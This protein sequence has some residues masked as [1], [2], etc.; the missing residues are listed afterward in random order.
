MKTMA[1]LLNNNVQN[2]EMKKINMCRWRRKFEMAEKGR[3]EDD[4][5]VTQVDHIC[6][7]KTWTFWMLTTGLFTKNYYKMKWQTKWWRG[8]QNEE[9]EA[10]KKTYWLRKMIKSNEEFE[11]F[12]VVNYHSSNQDTTRNIW[13]CWRDEEEEI[14]KKT[15]MKTWSRKRSCKVNMDKALYHI[16]L[17]QY[18]IFSNSFSMGKTPGQSTLQIFTELKAER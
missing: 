5:K 13:R 14:M 4:N 1:V 9:D 11:T 18:F 3:V 17:F 6:K 16:I 12:I 2:R 7:K 10:V 15:K 8:H